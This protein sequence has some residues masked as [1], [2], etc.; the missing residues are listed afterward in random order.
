MRRQTT[1]CYSD[2]EGGEWAET[3][4]GSL[5]RDVTAK[6]DKE[7]VTCT[8]CLRA[9]ERMENEA[10]MESATDATPDGLDLREA[11]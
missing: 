7:Q 11:M 5:A 3:A 2:F 6:R 1:I 8:S 10:R 9:M 4:C